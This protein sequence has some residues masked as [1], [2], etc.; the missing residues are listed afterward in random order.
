MS[1]FDQVIKS[2]AAALSQR[3]NALLAEALAKHTG[4][5]NPNPYDF[6][7]RLTKNEN[8]A[9]LTVFLSGVHILWIGKP[10]VQD[11][12]DGKSVVNVQYKLFE[13]ESV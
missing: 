13:K 12:G 3:E 10:T 11:L 9:G 8:S 6:I 5:V 1:F 7:N 4:Q 2:T